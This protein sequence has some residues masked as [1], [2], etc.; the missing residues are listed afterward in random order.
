MSGEIDL[1]PFFERVENGK[2]VNTCPTC[3]G[4]GEVR[5]PMS[6]PNREWSDASRVMLFLTTMAIVLVGGFVFYGLQKK[7]DMERCAISCGD[8]RLKSWTEETPSWSE[9]RPMGEVDVTHP[10]VPG[11][12]ECLEK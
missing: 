5:I 1:T 2:G 9:R 8:S 10:P 4:E 6:Q 12:C 11:K 7:S 3:H